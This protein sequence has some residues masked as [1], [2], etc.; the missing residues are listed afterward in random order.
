MNPGRFVLALALSLGLTMSA[1]AHPPGVEEKD[2]PL[3]HEVEAF[4][5]F[6]KRAVDPKDIHALRA[7]YAESFTH[8]HGSGKL[9]GKDAA[10]RLG[11]GG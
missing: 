9:D 2:Q 11:D 1:F 8:T 10:H 4:R 3:A 7:L 6:V 5:E